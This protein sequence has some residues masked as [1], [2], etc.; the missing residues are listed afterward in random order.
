[1]IKHSIDKHPPPKDHTNYRPQWPQ[2]RSA[3]TQILPAVP[4]PRPDR[5]KGLGRSEEVDHTSGTL[6]TV[7]SPNGMSKLQY[8]L[9]LKQLSIKVGDLVT[10]VFSRK[11]YHAH[12]VYR[13]ESIDEIH[14]FVEWGPSTVGPIC[15]NLRSC[16]EGATPHKGG[17]LMYQIVGGFDIPGEWMEYIKKTG[18]HVNA[19]D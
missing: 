18:V 10:S 7:A 17:A 6:E 13:V 4:E 15:L 3:N 16:R 8:A 5:W 11:P 19:N 2:F 14:R 9:F 1:M 12:G